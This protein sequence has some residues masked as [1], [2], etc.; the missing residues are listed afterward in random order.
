[1]SDA[2]LVIGDLRDDEV[3]AVIDLWRAA[4]LTRAWNDPHTDAHLALYGPG[5]TILAGR[6]DGTLV[7]TA[8]VGFDG[9]RASVYYVGVAPDRQGR[10]YGRAMMAACEAWAR[11]RGAPKLNLMVRDGNP[12][13]AFYEALGYTINAVRVFGKRLD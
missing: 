8:M 1:L 10:G 11:E 12:A 6:L 5:S 3:E 4:G 9:H 13:T 2:A 7:A